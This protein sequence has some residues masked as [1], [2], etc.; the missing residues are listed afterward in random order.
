MKLRRYAAHVYI[1]N[2]L[3]RVTNEGTDIFRAQYIFMAIY[4][5]TLSFVLL[6]YR[7]AKVSQRSGF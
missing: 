1:Y 7:T 5:L 3:Y 2:A 4:L 6:C